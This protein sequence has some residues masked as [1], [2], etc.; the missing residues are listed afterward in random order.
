MQRDSTKDKVAMRDVG[1]WLQ[2]TGE[3]FISKQGK[4]GVVQNP[5]AHTCSALEPAAQSQN[6]PGSDQQQDVEDRE[7]FIY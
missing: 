7:Q 5:G 4:S 2:W 1:V 6:H 3:S